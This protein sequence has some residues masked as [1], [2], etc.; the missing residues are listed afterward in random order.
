MTPGSQSLLAPSLLLVLSLV[1][2][3]T[4]CAPN[5]RILPTPDQLASPSSTSSAVSLSIDDIIAQSSA[6]EAEETTIRKARK[7]VH[8]ARPTPQNSPKD[9]SLNSILNWAIEHSDPSVI[10]EQVRQ[11]RRPLLGQPLSCWHC[12]P[13]LLKSCQSKSAKQHLKPSSTKR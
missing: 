4:Q 7:P 5:D 12:R 8:A 2:L 10:A 3:T 11:N 1:L 9:A 13:M 6:Q